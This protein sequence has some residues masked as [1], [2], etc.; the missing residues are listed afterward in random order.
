MADT[1][2]FLTLKRQN[3]V[4][5]FY[6]KVAK[7]GLDPDLDSASLE[8]ILPLLGPDSRVR[9]LI[10]VEVARL[11]STLT[12]FSNSA[13]NAETKHCCKHAKSFSVLYDT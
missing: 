8:T 10:Q 13:L 2:P 1:V 7:C 6:L 12:Q 3:F 9:I 5:L 4:K 11:Y